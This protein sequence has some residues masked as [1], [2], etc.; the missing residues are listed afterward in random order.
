MT[1]FR[2]DFRPRDE[3]A[4]SQHNLVNQMLLTNIDFAFAIAMFFFFHA[5]GQAI[6]VAVGCTF[7]ELDGF[8][9]LL[10]S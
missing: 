7:P 1:L 9:I 6:A 10:C 8:N 2:S 4:L 5:F 3:N